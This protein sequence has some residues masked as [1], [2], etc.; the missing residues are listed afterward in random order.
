[1]KR[2]GQIICIVVG[3]SFLSYCKFPPPTTSDDQSQKTSPNQ[4]KRPQIEVTQADKDATIDTLQEQV[5]QLQGKLDVIGYEVEQLRDANKD[6]LKDFDARL[7]VLENN[8]FSSENKPSTADIARSVSLNQTTSSNDIDSL[9]QNVD[10]GTNLDTT[11]PALSTWIE[12]NNKDSKKQNALYALAK[13]HFK[14]GDYPRAIQ[15][16]QTVVDEYPKSDEACDSRYH[17]GLSFIKLGD[18]KNAKLFFQETIELC[19]KH[20]AKSKSED[21]IKKISL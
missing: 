7:S 13:A 15:G 4:S 9:I 5:D 6:S 12:K 17:Q 8:N 2:L 14:K 10:K 20:T 21:E 1:M 19:P 11:I 3:I 18:A 16:F